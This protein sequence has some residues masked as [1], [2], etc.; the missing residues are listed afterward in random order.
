[1]PAFELQE[2]LGRVAAYCACND[3]LAFAFVSK[4]WWFAT[5]R[6]LTNAYGA[7]CTPKRAFAK[8]AAR[9]S[10]VDLVPCTLPHQLAL[11]FRW[12]ELT[13]VEVRPRPR[14]LCVNCQYVYTSAG[15]HYNCSVTKACV[16]AT[17]V[18]FIHRSSKACMVHRIH[19]MS[20]PTA[21]CS[22][23]CRALATFSGSCK[24][25]VGEKCVFAL[26][27]EDGVCEMYNLLIN[28]RPC[29]VL[30]HGGDAVL[31]GCGAVYVVTKAG[32]VSIHRRDRSPYTISQRAVCVSSWA[33][34]V[35]PFGQKIAIY[36]LRGWRCVR[37]RKSVV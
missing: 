22:K 17:S 26:L 29:T 8:L 16:V 1:M 15:G 36:T 19:D 12:Q 25:V 30:A 7:D 34:S 9:S 6:H 27:R 20:P 35:V 33:Q 14:P 23:P 31:S 28:A 21:L 10:V 32:V 37:D 11:L 2:V 5:R 18:V 3:I 13:T 24:G 4:A